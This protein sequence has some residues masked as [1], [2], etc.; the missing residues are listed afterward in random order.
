MKI[1]KCHFGVKEMNL[2]GYNFR[3][4]GIRPQE[5]KVNAVVNAKVAKTKTGIMKF[6]GLVRYYQRFI[7]QHI[8]NGLLEH[9]DP[10]IPLEHTRVHT[11]D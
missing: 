4:D 9:S 5:D 3:P 11:L 2:L 10:T 8:K 7:P 6:L 1:D